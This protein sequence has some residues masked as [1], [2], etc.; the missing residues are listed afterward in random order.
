MAVTAEGV[1][2]EEQLSRVCAK[3]CD[4]AQGYIFS[5]SVAA[6]DVPQLITRL[7]GSRLTR[8]SA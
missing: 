1:E 4:D 8:A 5:K 6:R 2:T 3:G 7:A